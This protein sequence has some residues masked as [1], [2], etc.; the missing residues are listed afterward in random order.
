MAQGETAK[1]GWGAVVTGEPQDLADWTVLLKHPFDPWV[2]LHAN[3]TVLRSPLFNELSCAEE[4]RDRAIAYIDR[5]N[6]V[7]ALSQDARPLRFGGLERDRIGTWEVS[8]LAVRRCVS[9]TVRIGKVRS[10]SR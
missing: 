10:R 9:G 2:E 5:L 4:V 1:A 3:Q 7:M 6:G 8:R